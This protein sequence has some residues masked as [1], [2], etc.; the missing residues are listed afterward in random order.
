MNSTATVLLIPGDGIGA[1]VIPAAAGVL[2]ALAPD[3]SFQQA[4][5]GWACFQRSGIALPPETLALAQAADAILFGAIQSPMQAVPGYSS[6]ILAL[7]RALDLWGNLRP[8]RSLPGAQP[9]F[10][11]LIVR[12]NSEG[13][14]SGREYEI[15]DGFIAERVITGAASRRI[16]VLACDEAFRHAARLGR[17]PHLTIVHKANVLKKTDGLFRACALE[18]A[19]AHSSL[20][21]DEMLVDTAAMW[22]ARDPSRFDIIVTTNLFGDILSDLAAGMAGG[23][24]LAPS[25]NI[26][27]SR[28][29]VFEPVHGSAPDIAGQ[30]IANPLATLRTTVMLLQHLGR[31][32]TAQRLDAAIERVLVA[33]PHTPD[34]GGQATTQETAEAVLRLALG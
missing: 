30:S 26:G 18:V 19:S 34:L 14:Y 22:L 20:R 1:E 15:P 17:Q 27:S 4:E 16:A 5:A 21:V 10:D 31:E 33:G 9:I 7:R 28:A 29:A 12:E 11:L 24:G 32:K 2:A 3:L 23:L 25:A 6:P 8:A 13:L